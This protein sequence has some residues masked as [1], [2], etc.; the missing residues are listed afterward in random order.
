VLILR[1]ALVWQLQYRNLIH[2]SPCTTITKYK[3]VGQVGHS[4]R[5]SLHT[6]ADWLRNSVPSFSSFLLFCTQ[7][8]GSKF[9]SCTRHCLVSMSTFWTGCEENCLLS[10][11]FIW[12]EC[13]Q[14]VKSKGTLIFLFYFLCVENTEWR[15]RECF[16]ILCCLRLIFTFLFS[17]Y[18]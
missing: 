15:L 8:F 2:R 12:C 6:S 9:R 11:L 7:V 10:H 17:N 4:D 14:A 1:A 18:S 13:I 5:Y 16:N 3:S